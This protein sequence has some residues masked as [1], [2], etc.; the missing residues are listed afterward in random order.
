[1]DQ[2]EYL[3]E[4]DDGQGPSQRQKLGPY[5]ATDLE[6]IPFIE[7]VCAL[8]P[9]SRLPRTHCHCRLARCRPH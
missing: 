8:A 7:Q 6:W 1:M 4:R 9:A 2:G 5:K 3:V